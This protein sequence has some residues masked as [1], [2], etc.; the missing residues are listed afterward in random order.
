MPRRLWVRCLAVLVAGFAV[1][2]S[3]ADL[4]VSIVNS[5]VAPAA[6]G[7]V[8]VDVTNSGS[9]A[10]E[11]NSY[12]IQLVIAPSGPT[13]TQL[14]FTLPTAQQLAYLSDPSYI[15]VNNSFD[16]IPPPFV[17]APT[18]TIYN[19]DTFN[20]TDSTANGNTVSIGAG[21]TYLLAVLPI[22]TLTQLDP[23]LGDSFS[24]SLNPAT[25]TGS[26]SGGATTFFDVLDSNGNE[27]SFVPFTST[28]G[29]VTIST[30]AVPEPSSLISGLTA[31]L[32]GAGIFAARRFRHRS[33]QVV[34]SHV[35]RSDAETSSAGGPGSN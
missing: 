29:T 5:T 23:Q 28:S 8:T 19:N 16:A 6:T 2:P 3:R 1:V 25:G 18:Q 20:A 4:V 7:S 34:R 11:I 27:T 33:W 22:T 17:G 12:G 9:S 30:A 26:S 31:I 35:Q 21:Q 10:V 24:V 15:F 14:A 32:V 13:L